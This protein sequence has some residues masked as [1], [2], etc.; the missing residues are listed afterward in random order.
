MESG[1]SAARASR[2]AAEDDLLDLLATWGASARPESADL[3]FA[4]SRVRNVSDLLRDLQARGRDWL[5]PAQQDEVDQ[6]VAILSAQGSLQA[7]SFRARLDQVLARAG[8]A[9]E[10]RIAERRSALSDQLK[11]WALLMDR[12]QLE[13]TLQCLWRAERSAGVADQLAAIGDLHQVEST[14][15]ATRQSIQSD[16]ESRMAA[17]GPEV[18]AGLRDRARQALG[19]GDPLALFQARASLQALET[20]KTQ[21]AMEEKFEQARARLAALKERARQRASVSGNGLDAGAAGILARAVAGA[22]RAIQ[23]SAESPD[24]WADFEPVLLAW[25]KT[26]ESALEADATSGEEQTKERAAAIE[27]FQ[28]EMARL[29]PNTAAQEGARDALAGE[30]AVIEKALHE[31][32]RSGGRPFQ[33]GLDRGAALVRRVKGQTDSLIETAAGRLRGAT[34]DATSF[35]DKAADQLPTARVVQ[36]R[37]WLEQVDGILASRE[38]AGIELMTRMI[39]EDLHGLRDLA[40]HAQRRRA[41][42]Q[43]AERDALRSEASRLVEAATRG[44]A[45]RIE[46]I[47]GASERADGRQLAKLRDDL[48]RLRISVEQGVRLQAGRAWHAAERWKRKNGGAPAKRHPEKAEEL[49]RSMDALAAAMDKNDLAALRERA[50]ALQKALRAVALTARP[51]VKAGVAVTVLGL[52][53]AVPFT[54]LRLRDRPQSIRLKLDAPPAKAVTIW[55]VRDGRIEGN[56]EYGSADEGISFTLRPGQYDVFVNEHYTGRVVRI[57]DD[58]EVGDIPLP[59]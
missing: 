28:S 35:I 31:A 29:L 21:G 33:E 39:Q 48:E 12:N 42:R 47:A 44:T 8:E 45:R 50:A 3:L 24:G 17:C 23:A 14:L 22:E 38:I 49:A 6:A 7:R 36:A 13:R 11:P 32:A 59:R 2:A 19:K 1:A 43:E 56:K 46:A 15:A 40:A 26:L 57:P 41:N 20:Q 55:L 54:L 10:A 51:W 27:T 5:P 52:L 37:L 58:K 9:L 53:A 30:A 18:A 4:I 16:L 34:R 25:Q